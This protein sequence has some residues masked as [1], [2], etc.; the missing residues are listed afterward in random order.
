VARAAKQGE[1]VDLE[2]P[3]AQLAEGHM[4]ARPEDRRMMKAIGNEIL[5]LPLF[6]RSAAAF[7][8]SA[9]GTRLA[10][11]VAL[12]GGGRLPKVI[13][14]PLP[15]WL[16]FRVLR[17]YS[18]DGRD[19]VARTV[20]GRGWDY[21]ERPLPFLF[22]RLAGRSRTVLDIGANTGFYSLL[23]GY[24]GATVLAFEPISSIADVLEGN[25]RQNGLADVR[26]FRCAVS[27]A[28]GS[29]TMFLP[30]ADHG[31]IETSAS[32]NPEF[33]SEHSTKI[34]AEACTVDQVSNGRQI[35]LIKIDVESL[36]EKVLSGAQRTIARCRPIIFVEILSE[37]DALAR[38]GREVGYKFLTYG[39]NSHNYLLCPLE[40]LEELPVTA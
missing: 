38:W 40:R 29:V 20:W 21:F 22:A 1:D 36:E 35:D 31:L 24:A 39:S 25:V 18:C 23:A 7:L 11:R 30:K 37:N 13:E 16:G 12:K 32:L 10:R 14:E 33:H 27:D 28:T 19:R 3:G 9:G 4:R 15:S 8:E 26:V 34:D 17:M 5:S 2:N 6:G